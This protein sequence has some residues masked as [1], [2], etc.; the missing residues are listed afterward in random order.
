MLGKLT[1]RN[2]SSASGLRNPH[3]VTITLTDMFWM[4]DDRVGVAGRLQDGTT[5]RL[6]V[7]EREPDSRWVVSAKGGV[8]APFKVVRLQ[9]GDAPTET[10]PPLTEMRTAAESGHVIVGELQFEE[11]MSLL[12]S[13]CTPSVRDMFGAQLQVDAG[14]GKD[15]YVASGDGER[16]LGTIRVAEVLSVTMRRSQDADLQDVRLAFR[17]ASGETYKLT[18]VDILTQGYL[19]IRTRD[20]Y[21]PQLLAKGLRQVLLSQK[22]VYLRLGLA[23]PSERHP[24]RCYLQIVGL[25]T[26]QAASLTSRAQWDGKQLT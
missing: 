15:W 23:E 18:I 16:S 1:P 21:S 11:I 14:G 4:P 22:L 26:G 7:G 9:I 17:D 12:E 8:L 5:V 10:H 13:S 20:G 19:N 2:L 24:D 25:I 6:R 3:E